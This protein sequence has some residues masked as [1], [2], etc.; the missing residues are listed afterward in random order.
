VAAEAVVLESGELVTAGYGVLD[1][2]GKGLKEAWRGWTPSKLE[3]GNLVARALVCVDV[4]RQ[5][6]ALARYDHEP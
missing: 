6:L 3:K 4:L 1:R 2:V 5:V